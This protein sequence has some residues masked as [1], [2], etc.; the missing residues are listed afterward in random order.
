LKNI[1]SLFLL[2]II[3]TVSACS[4]HSDAVYQTSFDFSKVKTYSIYQRDSTFTDTQNLTDNR[5]NSIEIAIEKTLDQQGFQYQDI[6]K[7]DLV[8]TYHLLNG[9]KNSYHDY[10]K[11]VRFCQNC[12]RANNWHNE[13]SPLKIKQGSLIID[14]VDPK[15]KRSVWRGIAPLKLK[16]KD[17]S[18]VV[19]EKIQQEVKDMFQQYPRY[20]FSNN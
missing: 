14:L 16:N 19:N 4:S 3:S 11:E 17:N 10:N 7:A 15:K 8:I 18:Q 9:N 12:L 1:T 2:L 20:S 5:R 13:G 6:A